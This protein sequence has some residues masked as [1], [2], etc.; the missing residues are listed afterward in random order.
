MKGYLS[1]D[2][3]DDN[4]NVIE[5]REGENAIAVNYATVM[6]LAMSNNAYLNVLLLGTGSN[7]TNPE[8]MTALQN[9]TLRIPIDLSKCISIDGKVA[10][11]IV[12]PVAYSVKDITE[13]GLAAEIGS[14]TIL[15]NY[16]ALEQKFTKNGK[17]SLKWTIQF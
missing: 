8:S 5:H 17:I 4:N 7:T 10:V 6:A 14:R 9:E 16:K 15:F 3:L 11:N 2:I 13:F 12:T 1:I